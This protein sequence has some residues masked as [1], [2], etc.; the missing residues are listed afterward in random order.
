MSIQFSFEM[1]QGKIEKGK[2]IGIDP[3]A[4]HLLS[5]DEGNHYGA[6]NKKNE[7]SEKLI[8]ELFIFSERENPSL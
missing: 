8:I 2:I 7:E 3:N 1:E 4:K 6:W 5:D